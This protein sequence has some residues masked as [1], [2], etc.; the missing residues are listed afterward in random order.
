MQQSGRTLQNTF[1]KENKQKIQ[2]LCNK[3]VKL[4]D[5]FDRGLAIQSAAGVNR[6]GG[7]HLVL[8][9]SVS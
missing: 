8:Y 4:K 1:L 6:L 2:D 5:S 3:L 7:S 9:P